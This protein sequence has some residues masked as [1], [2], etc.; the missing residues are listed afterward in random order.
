MAPESE[1]KVIQEDLQKIERAERA[2]ALERLE[3]DQHA[4]IVDKFFHEIQV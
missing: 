2:V 3:D 1:D 4:A